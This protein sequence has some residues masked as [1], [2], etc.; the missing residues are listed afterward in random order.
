VEVFDLMQIEQ[1]KVW[2]QPITWKGTNT[3]HFVMDKLHCSSS[4]L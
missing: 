1:Y 2:P 4:L 3:R